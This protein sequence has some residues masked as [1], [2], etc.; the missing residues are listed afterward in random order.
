LNVRIP[1]WTSDRPVKT[2]LYQFT[3]LAPDA[4]T[5]ATLKINGMAVEPLDI[6]NGYAR[7][8]RVWKKGDVLE[9]DLPMPVRRVRAHPGVE[10]DRGRV[11]LMRGPILYC[12]ESADNPFDVS[13][14]SLPDVASVAAVRRDALLGGVTVLRGRGLSE[15]GTSVTFQAVPYYAWANRRQGAMVVW[16][17]ETSRRRPSR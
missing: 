13:Q 6:R 15:K 10:A 7:I 1:A 14:F 8:R 16:I 11:A 5:G 3:A 2:D 12:L 4:R 9:M 17:P